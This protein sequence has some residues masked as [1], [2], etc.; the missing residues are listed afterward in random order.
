MSR[1]YKFIDHTADI[2]VELKGRTLEEMFVA[3]AEAWLVS[4]VESKELK[5][6]DNLKLDLSAT[7]LEELLVSFLN[8]LNFILINKKWLC[9]SVQF[10]KIYQE[11]ESYR[12]STELLGIKIKNNLQLKQEIKSVT[13]HQMEIVNKNNVYSTLVVFDI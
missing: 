5:H 8:E 2:A 11:A 1:D 10:I 12:L 4:I 13:Y 9:L 7:S 6:D 3:G